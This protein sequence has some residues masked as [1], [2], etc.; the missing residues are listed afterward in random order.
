MKRILVVNVNWLG[1]VI[2]SS[3]IF[4]ALKEAYPQV[5]ISC[6]ALPRVKEVLESIPYIDEIIVYDEK[7][8]HW[9]PFAKLGLVWSLRRR[10]FDVAFLLHRSLTRALLVYFAGI[11]QRV[12]YDAKGRG[13]FLTHEVEPLDDQVHR[14]DYYLNIL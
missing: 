10:H 8:R 13:R 4:K 9:N 6:L 7:G 12:G 14:C 3:P 2:F 5:H 11:P 1:D